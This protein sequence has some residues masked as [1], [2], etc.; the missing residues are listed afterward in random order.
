MAENS[1]TSDGVTSSPGPDVMLGLW[2]S[3][4]DMASRQAAGMQADAGSPA[5]VAHAS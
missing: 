3:W 1:T 2:S 5:V 4:V